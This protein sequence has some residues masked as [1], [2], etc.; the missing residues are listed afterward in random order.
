MK[1]ELID[2]SQ[3]TKFKTNTKKKQS[4]NIIYGLENIEDKRFIQK[5]VFK[6]T[7]TNSANGEI[8]KIDSNQ[9]EFA[10]HK[11]RMKT[12]LNN[13]KDKI[14]KFNMKIIND[15]IR[16]TEINKNISFETNQFQNEFK[17]NRN[18]FK[19]ILNKSQ[20][21]IYTF[22][23]YKNY[24]LKYENQFTLDATW[25]LDIIDTTIILRLNLKIL[26]LPLRARLF[27][28]FMPNSIVEEDIK[29]TCEKINSN[30]NEEYKKEINILFN[31]KLENDKYEQI[32]EIKLKSNSNNKCEIKRI[33]TKYFIVPVYF[34]Y[35]NDIPIE[36][37]S[38]DEDDVVFE[39]EIN[40]MGVIQLLP[41]DYLENEK[42]N[43]TEN[44]FNEH[45]DNKLLELID[46]IELEETPQSS[47]N[48]ASML[49]SNK[50][51]VAQQSRL[52]PIDDSS[53]ITNNENISMHLQ[54]K[55]QNQTP[56]IV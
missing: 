26:N 24:F 16:I 46:L 20:Q 33:V 40:E 21:L 56:Q 29:I 36:L 19:N 3:E 28:L 8:S 10:K 17:L 53:I 31:N 22:D 1:S 51:N 39:E 32:L 52:I 45:C 50:N 49:S 55:S 14:I 48:Q 11:I 18:N 47:L 12:S 4:L 9:S 2:T 27:E 41:E 37:K 35:L 5:F 7:T 15:N 44:G 34:Y 25:T 54:I 6:S 23:V 42:I 38:N 13:L 43:F 30:I